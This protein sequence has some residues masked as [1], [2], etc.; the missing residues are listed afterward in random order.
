MPATITHEL[1]AQLKPS[2]RS[3][4][5]VTCLPASGCGPSIST[6]DR[7]PPWAPATPPSQ[8]P[9]DRP[10]SI[11]FRP[12]KPWRA[13]TPRAPRGLGARGRL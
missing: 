4:S 12:W 5:R 8:S 3:G 11:L 13:D 1:Q 9:L 10:A 7:G 2:P 6:S